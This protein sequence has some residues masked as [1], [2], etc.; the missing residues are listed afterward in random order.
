MKGGGVSIRSTSE[1]R[2]SV[3]PKQ[4]RAND[5]SDER[6]SWSTLREEE[7]NTRS[8]AAL[9]RYCSVLDSISLSGPASSAFSSG[10]VLLPLC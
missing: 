5:E 4:Q 7:E 9:L 8:A 3:T 10:S 6:S 1:L 2:A